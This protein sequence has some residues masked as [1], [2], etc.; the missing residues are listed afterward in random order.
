M[1]II[2]NPI[3]AAVFIFQFYHTKLK[4]IP[5]HQISFCNI[6]VFAHQSNHVDYARGAYCCGVDSSEDKYCNGPF[7][8]WLLL[9][10]FFRHYYYIV[11]TL[12]VVTVVWGM[13][14][15]LQK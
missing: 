8:Y 11:L 1:V 10:S 15:W 12:F 7:T 9:S 2:I 13:K 6:Q 3:K 14:M 4:T 5:F